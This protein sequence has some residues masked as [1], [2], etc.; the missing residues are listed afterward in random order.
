MNIDFLLSDWLPALINWDKQMLTRINTDWSNSFFD[1]IAPYW[2]SR[3]I[4]IP[5]YVLIAG[6]VW[7]KYRTG[8]LYV[9]AFIGI[10]MV[11][12]NLVSSELIK[13]M[14]QRTRPC[15]DDTVVM[16]DIMECSPKSSF[17]FTSSHATNHFAL[18]FVMIYLI[19]FF[20]TTGW[21]FLLVLWAASI[22]YAQVYVGRHFLLDVSCGAVL[23][24]TIASLMA[25]LFKFLQ[26]K[27]IIPVTI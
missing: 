21:R 12:A 5:I 3:E 22:A 4:W 26:K 7:Y 18:S 20:R 2:R 25:W 14:V 23:G 9:L 15:N 16:R 13:D 17:S 19:P 6:A 10:T 11:V 1:F 24:I 8:G 27:F